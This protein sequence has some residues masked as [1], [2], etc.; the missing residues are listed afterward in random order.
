MRTNHCSATGISRLR[1]IAMV[2]VVFFSA[3]VLHANILYTWQEDDGQ[4]VNGTFEVLP[5]AQSAGEIRT[6]HV[7]SFIFEAPNVTY[8]GLA[9]TTFPIPISTTDAGFTSAAHNIIGVTTVNDVLTLQATAQYGNPFG[10]SWSSL[11][12][13]TGITNGSGHW[14]VSGASVPEPNSVCLAFGGIIVIATQRRRRKY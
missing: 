6:E 10:Q 14:I 11:R 4:F 12:A 2:F 13:G 1:Y 9:S 3:S 7:V 5:S 8:Q